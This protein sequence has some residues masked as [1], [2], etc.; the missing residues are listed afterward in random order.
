M[1]C[2]IIFVDAFELDLRAKVLFSLS[3]LAVAARQIK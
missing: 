2:A 1:V 3:T